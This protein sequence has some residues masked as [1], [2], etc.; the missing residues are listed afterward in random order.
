MTSSIGRVYAATSAL[1]VLFLAWAVI[2]AHPWSAGAASRDPRLVALRA[3]EARIHHE[4]LVVRRAVTHR[5]A[6][7]RVRLA[8]RRREIALVE[9]RHQQQL[10]ADRRAA[11]AAAAAATRYSSGPSVRVVSLPALTITR[12][13]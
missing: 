4:E 13:S 9:R 10:A 12:S 6:V 5:W 3:R 2:A 11:A 1:L 7:Y 8:H